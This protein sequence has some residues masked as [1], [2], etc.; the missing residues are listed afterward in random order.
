MV[1]D[2]LKLKDALVSS[3][4]YATSNHAKEVVSS[5]SNVNMS[6]VKGELH[7]QWMEYLNELKA[8]S[9]IIQNQQDLKVQRQTFISLSE[10]LIQTVKTFKVPGVIYQQHCPM[11]NGGVGADWLSTEE[12]ISNPYFGN[13]MLRCGETIEEIQF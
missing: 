9:E 2:Y 3:D 11:A 13:K 1:T 6:L 8:Q 4:A 7:M 10:T 12:E 5:L